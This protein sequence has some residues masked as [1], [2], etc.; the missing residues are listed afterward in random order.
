MKTLLF[1]LI[2]SFL[3][4]TATAISAE[5]TSPPAEITRHFNQPGTVLAV[6][7]LQFDS[8][9]KHLIVAQHG[10]FVIITYARWEDMWRF[11][12]DDLLEVYIAIDKKP[13]LVW[14]KLPQ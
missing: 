14:T 7:T 9:L 2:V 1:A 8:D 6:Y 3:S 12:N 10:P 13:H 5:A 4:F 11:D